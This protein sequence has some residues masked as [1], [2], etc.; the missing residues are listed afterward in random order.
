MRSLLALVYLFA[1]ALLLGGCGPSSTAG[2]EAP[3]GQEGAQDTAR[4]VCGPNGTRV[5]TPVVKARPDGVHFV[6]NNRLDAEV[7]YSFEGVDGGGGGN[8]APQGES[9]HVGGYPPGKVKVGCEKPPVDGVG[10]DYETLKVVDP[11]GFYKPVGLQCRGGMAAFG[12]PQYAA[13]AKGKE[14]D[15]VEMVRRGLSDRLQEGDTVESAGYPESQG[16]RTVRVVRDGR[17]VATVTFFRDSGSWLEDA[18][19]SCAGF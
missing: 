7:G 13:G 9:E 3:S 14:G 5:L 15:P 1:A 19:S 2:P 8:G 18:T 6:I 16:S 4:I 10:T 17:V 12:G 11:Q